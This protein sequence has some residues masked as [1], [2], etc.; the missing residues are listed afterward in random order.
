MRA[1]FSR[2][3]RVLGGFPRLQPLKGDALGAEQ[4][5]QALVADVI[6]HPSATRKSASSGRGGP[7]RSSWT[8]VVDRSSLDGIR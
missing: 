4:D 5:P 7:D 1:F 6:D 3:S 8:N 2:V